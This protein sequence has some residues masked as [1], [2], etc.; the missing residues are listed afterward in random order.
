MAFP[1]KTITI[2]IYNNVIRMECN[3]TYAAEFETYE[4]ND[5]YK[6]HIA[7]LD[8]KIDNFEQIYNNHISVTI[9]RIQSKY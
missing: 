3:D 8:W 1:N 9:A 6:A 4:I 5:P 2:D 7:M